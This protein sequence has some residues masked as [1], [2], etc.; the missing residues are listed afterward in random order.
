MRPALA[1][2]GGSTSDV[3][4]NDPHTTP[5]DLEM[6]QALLAERTDRPRKVTNEIIK[7]KAPITPRISIE[8]D[9]VL[10]VPAGF[11]NNRERHFRAYLTRRDEGA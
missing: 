9:E 7:A 5:E 10:G 3:V 1:T 4:E 8:L 6:S 2:V 11:W